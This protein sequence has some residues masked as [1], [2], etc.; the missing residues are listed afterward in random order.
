MRNG[1]RVALTIGMAA[2]LLAAGSAG[3]SAAA[4]AGPGEVTVAGPARVE[5]TAVVLDHS[6]AIPTKSGK[7][8][9]IMVFTRRAQRVRI[10]VDGGPGRA[11]TKLGSGCTRVRCQ[12]WRIY[13]R[14]SGDECYAIRPTATHRKGWKSSYRFDVCEPFGQGRV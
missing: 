12:K 14:R 8:V 3:A 1:I 11:M 10:S 5:R 4:A 6:R 9:R 2:S 13:A 7:F